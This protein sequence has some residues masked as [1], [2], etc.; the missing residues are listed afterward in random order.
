MPLI[1]PNTG[2]I[3]LFQLELVKFEAK[4]CIK[5]NDEPG[6]FLRLTIC[7]SFIEIILMA[8]LVSKRVC[9]SY[10]FRSLLGRPNAYLHSFPTWGYR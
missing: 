9:F 2:V 7:S 5:H 8:A 1:G 10:M 6:I 4:A 3:L